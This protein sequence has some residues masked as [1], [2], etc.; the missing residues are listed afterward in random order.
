MFRK[1]ITIREAAEKWVSQFNAVDRGM[2]ERL[3]MDHPDEWN[4]ITTPCVHDW[5]YHYDESEYGTIV[6]IE[7]DVYKIELT[8]GKEIE[9]ETTDFEV[10]RDSLLPMWGRMW[11]FGDSADDYW[12]EDMDGI[13][14]MSECGFRIYEHEEYGY[15]FGIDGCGYSFYEAHW[16]PLYKK[17]GLAW[18]DKRTEHTEEDVRKM[19]LDEGVSTSI[20]DKLMSI[21]AGDNVCIGGYYGG[22][23][24]KEDLEGIKKCDHFSISEKHEK[25]QEMSHVAD[26]DYYKIE[27]MV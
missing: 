13:K 24:G 5:V 27:R 12:L 3:M 8:G 4:E 25:V 14:L 10:I 16:E 6:G 17:R 26:N 2:I 22:R 1:G 9:C 20:V 18:H 21:K 23:I 11:N 7:G 15:W 19:L